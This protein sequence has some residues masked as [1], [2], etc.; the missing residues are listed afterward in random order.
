MHS[1][2]ALVTEPAIEAL[3]IRLVS[4]LDLIQPRS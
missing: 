1:V 4:T 2:V 3:D